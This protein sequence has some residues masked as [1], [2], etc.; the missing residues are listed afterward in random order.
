MSMNKLRGLV[1]F[2]AMG[3]GA[4]TG[5]GGVEESVTPETASVEQEVK[6]CSNN[7]QC[8][9]G[10]LCINSGCRL[11]VDGGGGGGSIICGDITC[12]SGQLCCLNTMTCAP[13]CAIP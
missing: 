6:Q 4:L 13:A 3:F 8:P 10:Y 2:A 12:A 5:C 1:M 7:N 11:A 9:S